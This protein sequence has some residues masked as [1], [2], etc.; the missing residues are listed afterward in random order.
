MG[1][2]F[3]TQC[4]IMV[5]KRYQNRPVKEF[6]SFDSPVMTRKLPIMWLHGQISSNTSSLWHMPLPVAHHFLSGANPDP[7]LHCLS[8]VSLS[9]QLLMSN[10]TY[11]V[12]DAFAGNP[13]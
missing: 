5:N 1:P 8:I 13:G 9:S 4:I 2:F 12:A 11:K 10:T 7:P 3:E 6:F